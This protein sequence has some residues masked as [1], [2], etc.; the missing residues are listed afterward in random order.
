MAANLPPPSMPPPGGPGGMPFTN[1]VLV[2]SAPSFLHS[3]HAVREWLFPCGSTRT[4]L[5]YPR[6]PKR[7]F[8]TEDDEKEGA[9]NSAEA[10]KKITILITL[11]HPD[12][13][14]K[15]LGSFKEFT[16]RLDER[17]SD[18]DAYMVPNSPD[19]PLPPPVVDKE[20]STILGEKLWQNFV[21]LEASHNC[22][23][24][25]YER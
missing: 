11:G 12:V 10:P 7:T 13:A 17:Y 19:I 6:P 5:F 16:S 25:F 21:S 14:I 9:D 18:I 15:F 4:A 2:T 8:G 1:T 20:T 23:K 24:A 3:F 22:I